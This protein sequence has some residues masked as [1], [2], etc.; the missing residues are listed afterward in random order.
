VR[1][2]RL[3]GVGDIPPLAQVQRLISV[4]AMGSAL[5]SLM[6]QLTA[7]AVCRSGL[8]RNARS[9]VETAPQWNAESEANLRPTAGRFPS[10]SPRGA[11]GGTDYFADLAAQYIE[12]TPTVSDR[13]TNNGRVGVE[14]LAA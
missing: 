2:I 9:S 14:G 6:L 3:R 1:V 5:P 12:A 11:S 13:C 7:T 4:V 8:T 10:T